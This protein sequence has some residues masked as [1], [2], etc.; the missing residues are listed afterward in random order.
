MQQV[1]DSGAQSTVGEP[2]HRGQR[3]SPANGGEVVG[4]FGGGAGGLSVGGNESHIVK[5]NAYLFC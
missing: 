2:D 5:G 4:P 1:L 3:A